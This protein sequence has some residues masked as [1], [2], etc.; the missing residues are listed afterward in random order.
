MKSDAVKSVSWEAVPAAR[1]SVIA[2]LIQLYEYDFSEFAKVGSRYG[3]VSADGLFAYEG[4]DSYWQEDGGFAFTIHADSRLAGF[5]SVN[6]WSALDYV[7]G[8]FFVLRKC[9]RPEWV[10]APQDCCS[11]AW[12]AGGKWG[13]LGTIR[14]RWPSGARLSDRQRM[15]RWRSGPVEGWPG[16]GTRWSGIVLS[17]AAGQ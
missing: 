11:R 5:A 3:E 14:R 4:L 16:D 9:R 6:R 15:A 10:G 7:V 12:P 8:E 13:W 17:F 2:N 1:K